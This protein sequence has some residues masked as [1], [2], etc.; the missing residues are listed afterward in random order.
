MGP[1]HKKSI[2]TA[3]KKRLFLEALRSI[4][5]VSDAAETVGVSRDTPYRWRRNDKAFAE[6]WEKYLDDCIADV[7]IL[8]H[9]R[10]ALQDP[11]FVKWLLSVRRPEKYSQK[12]QTDHSGQINIE[13]IERDDE[14]DAS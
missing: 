1:G 3:T 13:I 4:G 14:E 12:E 9:T 11:N 7:E 10:H 5:T 8:A 2:P 6:K